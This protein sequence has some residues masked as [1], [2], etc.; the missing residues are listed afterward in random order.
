MEAAAAGSVGAE[1]GAAK[2]EAS[3]H[4]T[5]AAAA[6][7]TRAQAVLAERAAINLHPVD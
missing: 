6:A 5:A 1:S 3:T 4:T 7:M 2:T